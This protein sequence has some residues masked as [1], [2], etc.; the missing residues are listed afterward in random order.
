[1]MVE[2]MT[3]VFDALA[4]PPSRSRKST[5]RQWPGHWVG[6]SPEYPFVESRN[7]GICHH[8]PRTRGQSINPTSPEM[9]TIIG[10]EIL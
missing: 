9:V 1:M 5:Q 3:I 2:N 8:P 7:D 6:D 10:S 4:A